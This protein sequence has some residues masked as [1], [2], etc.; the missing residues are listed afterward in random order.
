MSA[1]YGLYDFDN[2][3]WI[4]LG[5]KFNNG[6]QISD[7]KIIRFMQNRDGSIFKI[8]N[9]MGNTPDEEDGWDEIIL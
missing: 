8:I 3:E 5:K 2:K 6:F 9:D 1:T 4:D 7:K